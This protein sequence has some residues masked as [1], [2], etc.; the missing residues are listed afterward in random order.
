MMSSA[1]VWDRTHRGTFFR[2]D[3]RATRGTL[4]RGNPL[5]RIAGWA[6]P[7]LLLEDR[8]LLWGFPAHVSMR[9]RQKRVRRAIEVGATAGYITDVTVLALRP[10]LWTPSPTWCRQYDVPPRRLRE[11]SAT[12]HALAVEAALYL[13]GTDARDPWIVGMRNEYDTMSER[14]KGVRHHAARPVARPEDALVCD[15]EVHTKDG[16][17]WIEVISADYTGE[18]IDAKY[19]GIRVPLS[20]VATSAALARR[21]APGSTARVC[22]HF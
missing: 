13:H 7:D 19:D 12:H 21:V 14:R 2:F 17:R 3:P 9:T 10:D 4:G 18:E 1:R 20:V 16:R 22:Y 6:T 15:L 8:Y 5:R 11:S